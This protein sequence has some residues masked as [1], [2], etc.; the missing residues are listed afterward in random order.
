[1][2]LN[3]FLIKFTA[4]NISVAYATVHRCAEINFSHIHNGMYTTHKQYN[5]NL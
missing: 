2:I 5:Y 4:E 1:M 3:S